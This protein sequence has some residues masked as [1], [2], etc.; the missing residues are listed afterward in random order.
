MA[1]VL[2]SNSWD[3]VRMLLRPRSIKTLQDGTV[4]FVNDNSQQRLSAGEALRHREVGK[5]SNKVQGRQQVY[6]TWRQAAGSVRDDSLNKEVSM[7][8]GSFEAAVGLWRN[9]TGKLFDLEA[10]IVMTAS[11]TELQTGLVKQLKKKLF[12]LEANIVMTASATELQ[13]GLVKQLKKKGLA[14]GARVVQE[15]WLLLVAETHQLPTA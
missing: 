11:A 8:S 13:T 10:N 4:V 2:D 1:Q 12:D 5:G 9:L 7:L 14:P 15:E 6:S 3:L